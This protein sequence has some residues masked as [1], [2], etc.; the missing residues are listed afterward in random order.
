M[1]TQHDRGF[2]L[3]QRLQ[4]RTEG[5]PLDAVDPQAVNGR[6]E[7]L[8]GD[9]FPS[10]QDIPLP[11]ANQREPEPADTTPQSTTDAMALTTWPR[12][13]AGGPVGPFV[14]NTT[15]FARPASNAR[16]RS[17]GGSEAITAIASKPTT[18]EASSRT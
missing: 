6:P 17:R 8:G 16:R 10:I 3:T 7:P 2:E 1:G 4:R 5:I 11:G 14:S 18:G 12:K 9:Q 15:A 13:L